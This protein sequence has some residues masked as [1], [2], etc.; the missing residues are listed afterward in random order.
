MSYYQSANKLSFKP[1]EREQICGWERELFHRSV[2]NIRY[3]VWDESHQYNMAQI[4]ALRLIPEQI[5][6]RALSFWAPK[7]NVIISIKFKKNGK[8]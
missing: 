7:L 5:V 1:N 8:L 4:K 2:V 6:E 3:D